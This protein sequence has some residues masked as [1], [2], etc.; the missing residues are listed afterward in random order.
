VVSRAS[1]QPAYRQIADALREQIRSGQLPPGAQLPSE[2]ELMQAWSVSGKTIVAALGQLR[3]EGR[4]ISYQGRGVFVR[5]PARR[6]RLASDLT[7]PTAGGAIRGYY[8]ALEREGLRPATTATVSV[9]PCPAEVAEWLGV[10]ADAQ[11][12]VR[13]RVMR[14]EGQ[15]PDMLADS[16]FPDWVI[17][18]APAL[19]DPSQPG[20]IQKLTEA[21]GPVWFE[22]VISS[23]MPD[24]RERELLDLP[25]G[26]PVTVINGPTFDQE[27]RTLTHIVVAAPGDRYEVA[28]RY[29]AVPSDT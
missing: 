16:Y 28:Y 9:E 17:E 20:Q 12:T 25:E 4:I 15:A 3:A 11:V 24:Q 22:D 18:A 19:A 14:A 7:E 1:G 27:G 29:G 10:E 13:R 26:V 8:A 2:R 6:R 21:F 5:T 23:R